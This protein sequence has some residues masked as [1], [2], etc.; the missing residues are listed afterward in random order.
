MAVPTPSG[1]KGGGAP[2]ASDCGTTTTTTTTIMTTTGTDTAKTSGAGSTTSGSAKQQLGQLA[3]Q[4]CGRGR[5][6][7]S[8]VLS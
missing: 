5:V 2:D 1:W 8:H 7:P 6:L 4:P 3:A